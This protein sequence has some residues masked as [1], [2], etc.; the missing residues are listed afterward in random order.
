[1][2]LDHLSAAVSYTSANG[3]SCVQRSA[4]LMLDMPK[5]TLVFGVMRA[6][7]MDEQL[8]TP[9]SSPVPFI[10]AWVEV[11]DNVF[12][13]TLLEKTD[14]RLVPFPKNIYYG[15]NGISKTWRLDHRTFDVVAKRFTLS[16][17]FRH[18]KARA[19]SW[20]ITKALLDAAGVPFIAS[21]TGTILPKAA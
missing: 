7:S 5:G 4:A 18:R 6:A 15:S 2:S 12:A 11:G 9:G 3:K 14:M 13:P 19:G 16:A 21:E 8:E 20:E 1:M 10:H 17:A